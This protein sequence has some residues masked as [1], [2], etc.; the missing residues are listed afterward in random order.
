M[1]G[2]QDGSFTAALKAMPRSHDLLL[3]R[4]LIEPRRTRHNGECRSERTSGFKLLQ[5]AYVKNVLHVSR[6]PRLTHLTRHLGAG[7]SRQ[8]FLN[9]GSYTEVESLLSTVRWPVERL[10]FVLGGEEA[11]SGTFPQKG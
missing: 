7:I 2:E 6:D 5:A 1:D 9:D 3:A 11:G 10:N 4:A 8:R